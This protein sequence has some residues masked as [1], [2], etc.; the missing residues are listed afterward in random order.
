MLAGEEAAK[1]ATDL[2]KDDTIAFL[3]SVDSKVVVDAGI[4]PSLVKPKRSIGCARR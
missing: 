3:I 2:S 4:L 1:E